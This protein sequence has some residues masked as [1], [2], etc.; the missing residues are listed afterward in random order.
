MSLRGISREGDQI[1][2][3][4]NGSAAP[5]TILPIEGGPGHQLTEARASDKP[6]G[7]SEDSKR[8]LFETK[9]SGEPVMLYAPVDGGPMPQIKLPEHRIWRFDPVLSDDGKHILY[10]VQEGE[11][12]L[13]TLKAYS[14][15]ED[16]SWELSRNV[17]LASS[18][19]LSGAGGIHCRDGDDFLFFE[20]REGHYL[21]VASL[22]QGPA[23]VMRTFADKLPRSVAVHGNRIAY[24]QNSGEE[25]SLFLATAGNETARRLLK[26][27][28]ILDMVVWSPSGRRMAAGHFDRSIG[29]HFDP[30]GRD[31]IVFE[32]R[33]SG[34]I[35]GEP[36][37]Y[38]VPAGTWWNPRWLPNG[39]GIL[40]NGLD[41]NVWLIPLDPNARPVAITQDDPNS[42]WLYKLSPDGRYIAYPGER[43]LGSSI[44]LLKLEEPLRD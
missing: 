32:V 18:M 26:L 22:P 16:W 20:K 13:P 19:R 21:L 31:L 34:E 4:Q 10:A 40:V 17:F 37:R 6:F 7:W 12:E 36:R 24:V 5:L 2:A 29:Y 43:E 38:S 41:A 3:I 30:L 33:P 8:V 9:L 25:D 27:Q 11:S 44:W 14:I 15:D 23:R 28:G 42:V 39:R 1:L 35:R